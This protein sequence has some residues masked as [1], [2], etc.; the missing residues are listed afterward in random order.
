MISFREKLTSEKNWS[1][2][3]LKLISGF[4]ETL[5]TCVLLFLLW[6]LNIKLF[7]CLN[8]FTTIIKKRTR[9]RLMSSKQLWKTKT[10]DNIFSFSNC[11]AQ[12]KTNFYLTTFLFCIIWKQVKVFMKMQITDFTKLLGGGCEG[13]FIGL[14]VLD[15]VYYH[16]LRFIS[17]P[18]PDLQFI[19]SPASCQKPCCMKSW[20]I[21]I[22]KQN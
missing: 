4:M 19:A 13:W 16:S 22:E 20:V 14:W 11:F 18:G 1:E 6:K 17:H 10:L 2:P 7:S 3:E 5:W 12:I 21:N 15:Q 9:K 8:Y